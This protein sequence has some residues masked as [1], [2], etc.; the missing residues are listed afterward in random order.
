MIFLNISKK[1]Y[2]QMVKLASPP[3]KKLKNCIWAFFVGGSICGFGQLLFYL[4]KYF[5]FQEKVCYALV[6]I[7]IIFL[8]AIFTGLG[9]FDKLAKKAG[10]GTL[11]PV[12]G[13]A[14]AVS[15]PAIEFKSEGWV[16]GLGA[17]IFT[18]AGPVIV[19][20]TVASVVYGL[21]YWILQGI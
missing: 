6:S 11:V 10:A 14:N 18:I 8:T 13:F 16:L 7:S 15:S 3:S 4:F 9:L 2:D 17:K 19:Y 21:I 5:G 1:E 20:G 12:S